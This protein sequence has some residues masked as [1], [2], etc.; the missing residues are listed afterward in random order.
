MPLIQD[1]LISRIQ[2]VFQAK[3][4]DAER[5]AGDIAQ[6]YFDYT[7]IA[8]GP[9]GSPLIF[10]GTETLMLR[11]MLSNIMRSRLQNPMAAQMIGNAVISYW[12]TP[13]VTTATGGVVTAI[14]PSLGVAKL[15]STHARTVSEAARSFAS[16][17]H[18]MTSTVFIV[19]PVPLAPGTLK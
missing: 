16:A 8:L 9:S 14:V 1:M 6:A 4:E 15:Q 2:L 13:P 17:L 11:R 7:K 18:L 10:K 5:V 12:L 3:S 19:E